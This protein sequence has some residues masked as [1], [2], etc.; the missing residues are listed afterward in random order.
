MLSF[1]QH[2][3][4]QNLTDDA[5]VAL[6]HSNAVSAAVKYLMENNPALGDQV[7]IR[8]SE[9]ELIRR[10]QQRAKENIDHADA[11]MHPE[12]HEPKEGA[13]TLEELGE[14]MQSR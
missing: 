6:Y 7:T 10:L 14:L 8:R 3:E 12:R 13:I 4:A 9:V 2:L 5:S 11:I 1:N